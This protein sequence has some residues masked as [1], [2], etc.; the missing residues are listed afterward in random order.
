MRRTEEREQPD[1]GAFA[2]EP[3]RE[4]PRVPAAGA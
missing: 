1:L 3:P 2:L 4:F